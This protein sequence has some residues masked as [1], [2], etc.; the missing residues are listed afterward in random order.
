VRLLLLTA[1]L[2]L[3]QAQLKAPDPSE[4]IPLGSSV[5]NPSQTHCVVNYADWADYQKLADENRELRQMVKTV[6]CA[7][8]TVVEPPKR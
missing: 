7:S 3:A 8:V 6:K 1:F 4:P 5:C 2:P